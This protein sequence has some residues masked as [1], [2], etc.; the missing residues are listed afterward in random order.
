MLG[1]R[2]DAG[3]VFLRFGLF[4]RLFS[5]KFVRFGFFGGMACFFRLASL[6]G[7]LAFLFGTFIGKAFFLGFALCVR[8]SGRCFQYRNCQADD[9]EIALSGMVLSDETFFFDSA[10]HDKFRFHAFGADGGDTQ[11]FSFAVK[12]MAVA[13]HMDRQFAIEYLFSVALDVLQ[14]TG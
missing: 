10:A 5:G 7:S 11:V 12:G 9:D 4:C 13:I 1:F 6:F 14:Q 8:F 2:W 3:C